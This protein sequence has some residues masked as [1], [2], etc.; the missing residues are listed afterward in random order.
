MRSAGGS[1]FGDVSFGPGGVRGFWESPRRADLLRKG[2]Y[3]KCRQ[4]DAKQYD[5]DGKIIQMGTS[6][7]QPLLGGNASAPFYVPLRQRRP[8]HP[9]RLPK[10]FVREFSAMLFGEHRFPE[11]A[12]PGDATTED[13]VEGLDEVAHFIP[14]FQRMRDLGGSSGTACCSW[15][16][17]DGKPRVQV[18]K[19]ANVTVHSWD[20]RDEFIPRKV[21]EVYQFQRF[22]P[23][24]RG[25]YSEV[26]YWYRRDW[27]PKVDVIYLPCKV[28]GAQEPDWKPD[29]SKCWEHNDGICHFVWIQNLPDECEDG[30]SDYDGLFDNFDS[31]DVM[32]SILSRGAILNLDPTLKLKMDPDLV[33]RGGVKK[34]SDN[35]LVVGEDGDAEYMELAGTSIEAGIKL[36]NAKRQWTLETG[37]MVVPDPDKVAAAGTSSVALK[38]LY[39][40]MLDKADLMRGTYGAGLKR[41]AEPMLAVA[42]AKHRTVSVIYVPTGDVDAQGKEVLGPKEVEEFIDLPPCVKDDP[43]GE[44]GDDGRPKSI[45]VEREPGSGTEVDPQWPDYFLPTP[46]DQQATVT[47]L[48]TAAGGPGTA[49]MSKKSATELVAKVFDKDPNKEWAQ[50]EK[51]TQQTQSDHLQMFSGMQQPGA[52]G[53][54][55][56]KKLTLPS[57]VSM[58]HQ[59]TPAPPPDLPDAPDNTVNI[60]AP[61]GAAGEKPDALPMTPTAASAIITVNEARKSMGLTP[62]H[63]PDGDISLAAYQAKYAGPIAA[64]VNA[65]EGSIGL[66]PANAPPAGPPKPGGGPPGAGG[67]PKPPAPPGAPPHPAGPPAPPHPLA[68]PGAPP[69]GP[70]KPPMPPMPFPPKK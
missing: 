69:A 61:P 20:D 39:K 57:G 47:T 2:A 25:R 37:Q 32:A 52:D 70:P 33:D 48:T 8:S 51:E 46:S 9:Y 7:T 24:E 41:L 58:E 3:Y 64:S 36:F 12:V 5:F 10:V 42:R 35:A 60:G 19:A 68:P 31:L 56:K 13:F 26:S 67:S 53:A 4:H 28:R 11:L 18:H 22:E 43:S 44:M 40:P 34:G 50:I 27:T 14:K 15:S 29:L 1:S 59:H 66:K 16:F 65:G 45:K 54:A 30:E 23:D 63:G 49:I 38:V 6:A 21:S 62:M 17:L 55:T